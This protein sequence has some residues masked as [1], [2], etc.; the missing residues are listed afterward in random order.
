MCGICGQFRFDGREVSSKSLDNMMLKLARRGPDS[1]GQWIRRNIGFGHQRLSIID[2]SSFGSQPMID[3]NLELTLVFNGTIYNYKSLRAQL[4]SK[5][6]SFFS[7][8]DTEVILKAY[9]FWGE[10]CLEHL[11]GMFAFAIWDISSKKLFVARDRMGIKPLYFNS[12]SEAFT[13]ASNSQALLTQGIDKS[14]NPIALQ[15]QLSLHG[16]VPAPNTII[17]GIQ[18]LKPGTFITIDSDRHI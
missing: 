8:S 5:G 7:Q 18:K 9:H 3:D 13:F 14:V 17:N 12:T 1:D 15:Q 2:L 4:S 6:Y 16:V 10:T 11:D